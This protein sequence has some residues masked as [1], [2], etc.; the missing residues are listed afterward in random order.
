MTLT[1]KWWK[2]WAQ[3]GLFLPPRLAKRR[4]QSVP[5]L[6]QT[7]T[8]SLHGLCRLNAVP[9]CNAESI[10]CCFKDVNVLMLTALSNPGQMVINFSVAGAECSN[11]VISIFFSTAHFICKLRLNTWRKKAA[12]KGNFNMFSLQSSHEWANSSDL[13]SGVAHGK[14]SFPHVL[15]QFTRFSQRCS[16]C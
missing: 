6:Y 14:G 2:F 16:S 13:R 10:C 5:L 12:G 1:A 11:C 8:S 7:P 3:H 4:L 9:C 15:I